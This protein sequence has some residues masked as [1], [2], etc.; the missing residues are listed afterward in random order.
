MRGANLL[1]TLPRQHTLGCLR[2]L[3]VSVYTHNG[4]A[5]R[6]SGAIFAQLGYLQLN[7]CRHGISSCPLDSG[8]IHPM[9]ER[10]IQSSASFALALFRAGF[11]SR[12]QYGCCIMPVLSAANSQCM[13]IFS[14]TPRDRVVARA[15][16]IAE[17]RIVTGLLVDLLGLVVRLWI[18]GE[19]LNS[20]RS[21]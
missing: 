5:A 15:R 1:G 18:Y 19:G 11:I 6:R 9:K 7:A 2:Q 4:V 13:L 12:Q 14:A 16:M 17:A 20:S 3:F 10:N 21:G 8:Q